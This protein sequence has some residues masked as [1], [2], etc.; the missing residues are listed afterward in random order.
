MRRY[1][2]ERCAEGWV[3]DLTPE[4]HQPDVA[5]RVFPGVQQPVAIG[6]FTRTPDTRPDVPARIRYRSVHGSQGTKF[7][8]LKRIDIDDADWEDCPDG[9]TAPFLPAGGE[10]WQSSPPL[11]DLMPWQ[12]PGIKPNRTWVYAP[13]ASTLKER[14][15]Q[16]LNADATEQARLFRETDSSHL[17]K[18]KP[19]LPGFSHADIPVQEEVGE[20]LDPVPIA[21]RSFDTQLIIPDDRL[22][23]R[24]S[25]PLWA[26][27]DDHQIYVTE[28]HAQPLRVG[29]P[30][31]TFTAFT[32]DMDHYKGSAGGRVLPLYASDDTSRP[33][34]APGLLDVLAERLGVPVTPED[35]LA[36]VA[37]VTAH[38]GFT[39]HFAE[40][41]RTPGIRV[42]LTADPATW[43]EAAEV[44][45]RVL[46]LHTRGHRY[47]DPAAGRPADA[48]RA[49]D[50]RRPLV[51]KPIAP[52]PMP[53]DLTYD[54][55]KRELHVG[56]G[57]IGPVDPRLVAYE[58]SGMNVLRK[59]FGYRRAT[60]PQTRGEQSPLD[61]IR[62]T[63]WPTEYT[64]DLLNLLNVLTLVVDL[65]PEQET[66]L[67]KILAGPLVTVDDLTQAGVL[68]VPDEARKLATA[69]GSRKSKGAAGEQTA[70][71]S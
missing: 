22:M 25:P 63:T 53:D 7:D 12:A 51:L 13:L 3:I 1:L 2:R 70:L 66:L 27:R 20:S 23:H 50:D 26:V 36:Y 6:I 67:E 24:P 60:R 52:D 45:R 41:L 49:P 59:W 37:A 56:G 65:E 71:L 30:A 54:A 62:P 10:A 40:D 55:D 4:G 46:W 35:L 34:I 5:T 15:L 42:P 18:K 58:V 17:T 38:P 29:G 19:G 16:L 9:W 61:D 21:Y 43:Q 31:L 44:G 8:E 28:Q 11:G 48:P 64:T 32:P 47:T 69:K 33:N 57:L 68:P 39:E 14:W